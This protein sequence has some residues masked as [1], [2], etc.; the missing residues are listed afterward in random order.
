MSIAGSG[1]F[2]YILYMDNEMAISEARADLGSVAAR[3]QYGGATTYL[4]KHGRRAAAIV[5]AP[6]AELLERIEDLL[7]EQ[8]VRAALA[9]LDTGHEER[10][11]FVP[12]TRRTA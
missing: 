12:R 10:R 8:A 5:P 4:T 1:R 6:A 11:P 9:D 3:S 7:D 2:R